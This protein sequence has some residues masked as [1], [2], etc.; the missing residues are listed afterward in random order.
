MKHN[1]IVKF[2]DNYDYQNE[3]NHIKDDLI[4]PFTMVNSK[5]FRCRI[6]K[7][8]EAG[9]LFLD[10][11]HTVFD[12]TSS[13]AVFADL[14]QAY[15]DQEIKT[16]Y[17]YYTIAKRIKQRDSKFYQESR[18]YFAKKYDSEGIKWQKFPIVDHGIN[19]DN[20]ADHYLKPTG[21]NK[22]EYEKF[23]KDN[24]ILVNFE[25]SGFTI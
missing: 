22:E 9:Y 19:R 17:Y 21:I 15:Y 4:Q 1:I 16:D 18:D 10:V 24:G 2:I 25:C 5:L 12:G 3:L 23:L 13:K 6:F 20:Y 7:T 11:H 8:P 14:L